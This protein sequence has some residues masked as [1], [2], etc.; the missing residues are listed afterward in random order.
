MRISL[1]FYICLSISLIIQSNSSSDLF[2][3]AYASQTNNTNSSSTISNLVQDDKDNRTSIFDQPEGYKANPRDLDL[4]GNT[5]TPELIA[6]DLSQKDSSQIAGFPLQ[7]YSKDDVL[8]VFNTLSDDAL[9]KVMTSI[10]PENLRIIFDK[11]LPFEYES[12]LERISQQTQNHI[13]NITGI[14][15]E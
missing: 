11:F 6:K 9:E 2:Q 14:G 7:E 15:R 4:K 3:S 8:I 1:F 13:V 5:L 12:I 10:T